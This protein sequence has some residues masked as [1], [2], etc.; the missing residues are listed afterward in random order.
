MIL[1][2]R[3][4][5]IVFEDNT[6]LWWLKFLKSGFRHCKMYV[7]ITRKIYVEI[8]PLSNQMFLLV[9]FFEKESDFKKVIH[10]EIHLKTKIGA[11]PLK[12]AP[13]GAFTCVE[14]VKRTLGIHKFFVVTPYQLYKY[15]LGCRKK[16]LTK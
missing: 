10:R 16:V 14:A 12:T 2:G 11:A 8:N 5:Y 6:T 9:H 13:F 4:V 3:D 7:K 15:I 1:S